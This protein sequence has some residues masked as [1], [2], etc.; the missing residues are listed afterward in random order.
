M[1]DPLY[2]QDEPGPEEGSASLEPLVD[3]DVTASKN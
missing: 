3:Q 2:W 1:K